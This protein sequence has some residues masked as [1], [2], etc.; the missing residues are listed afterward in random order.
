MVIGN[1]FFSDTRQDALDEMRRRSHCEVRHLPFPTIGNID[2]YIS[3]CGNIYGIVRFKGKYLTRTKNLLR[4]KNGFSARLSTAPHREQ[5]VPMAVLMY[6]AFVLNTWE[7]DVQVEHIN[8]NTFDCRP[9]NL[10]LKAKRIPPE[11][12][13]RM[14]ERQG[15]YKAHFTSVCYSVNYTT[16]YDLQTCKDFVQ[17]A[18]IY[19]CTDGYRRIQH[20][21]DIVGLWVKYARYR[22]ID[23]HHH[24]T[25]RQV[26]DILD[27]LGKRD[28]PYEF[29]PLSVVSSEKQRKYTRLYFEGNTS[30]EIAEMCG[31]NRSTV[32]RLVSRAV[33]YMRK[34]Y[35]VVSP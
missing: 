13:E 7:P 14:K 5:N 22:A 29:D 25:N 11:W 1:G 9:A 4:Y 6:C 8:G 32:S 18:F 12:S 16:G 20:A 34:H 24:V 31:V 35:G 2:Y 21:T 26:Y 3:E 19:L 28:K 15:I 10:R 23:Y 27:Y 33:K 30:T 17:Q